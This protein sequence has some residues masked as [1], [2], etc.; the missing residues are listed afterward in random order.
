MNISIVVTFYQGLNILDLCILKIIETVNKMKYRYEI[1]IVNDNPAISLNS[2]KE[3][4]EN[5]CDITL[6]NLS[7]NMG[8]A[9]ACNLGVPKA[10]YEYIVL[11]DCDIIPQNNWLDELFN[12]YLHCH[13][14]GSVSST[15][16]EADTDNLFGYGIGVHNVDF[17]LYKRH[18]KSDIFTKKDRNF[19]MISSGCLLMKKSLYLQLS[20]QDETFYNAD[21]DLDLTYRI[22][23]L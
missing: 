19:Y 18:G 16:I 21:N 11:M 14:P 7:L 8:Y 10:K 1:L 17:I 13:N 12:T 3:K 6:L 22:H 20:G 23:L 9:K 5:E 4:Y 15:I 2:L